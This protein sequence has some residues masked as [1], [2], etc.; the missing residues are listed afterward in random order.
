[1]CIYKL[2]VCSPRIT[3]GWNGH[4]DTSLCVTHCAKPSNVLWV[5]A[6]VVMSRHYMS[7]NYELFTY[8]GMREGPLPVGHLL[9]IA[10]GTGSCGSCSIC[11][12]K[13]LG[14]SPLLSCD[15]TR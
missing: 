4:E 15:V 6:D 9:T 8:D 10:I 14:L 13:S 12:Q 2:S 1:M 3:K 7:I 11:G 5:L